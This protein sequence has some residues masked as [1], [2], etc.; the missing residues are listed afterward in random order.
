RTNEFLGDVP[1]GRDEWSEEENAA[2]ALSFAVDLADRTARI[3]TEPMRLGGQYRDM[4]RPGRVK[5]TP[6]RYGVDA[7]G[8]PT[9]IGNPVIGSHIVWSVDYDGRMLSVRCGGMWSYF[10][11]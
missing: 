11:A 7:S 3:S 9:A 5:V 1:A 6:L 10:T 2:T 4:L 8:R